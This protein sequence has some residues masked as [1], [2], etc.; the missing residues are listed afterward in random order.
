M[1]PCPVLELMTTVPGGVDR[2]VSVW[3]PA[4][5]RY[6]AS[7]STAPSIVNVMDFCPAGC[8]AP[9]SVHCRNAY[10]AGSLA[11]ACRFTLVP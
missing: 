4:F 1:P 3:L 11:G 9:F 7:A 8:A 5:A 6:R 10:P 2:T